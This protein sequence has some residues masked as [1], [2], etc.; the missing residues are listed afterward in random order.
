MTKLELILTERRIDK[1]SEILD[2]CCP[3]KDSD[4][5]DNL[6]FELDTIIEELEQSKNEAILREKVS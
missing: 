4:V 1:I 2:L 6:M 5:I 3:D